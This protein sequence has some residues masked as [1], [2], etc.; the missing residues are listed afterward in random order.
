M[1]TKLLR[2]KSFHNIYRVD[3]CL[4]N[5]GCTNQPLKMKIIHACKYLK[6]SLCVRTEKK[7]LHD[8]IYYF[9]IN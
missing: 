8:R 7:C 1:L 9:Q 3:T 2:I 4:H 6:K 5:V